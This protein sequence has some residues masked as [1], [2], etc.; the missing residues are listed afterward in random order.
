[1]A[2][3]TREP[4]FEATI[5]TTPLDRACAPEQGK[6]V[7]L[8]TI[9]GSAMAFIDGTVVN[10]ALP[11]LQTELNATVAQ[12]QWV[13][14]AYTLMLAALILAGGALGD[15]FGRRRIYGIGVALFAV[16]RSGADWRPTID[17]L[18]VARAVQGVGGALLVPGS[19]AII[20][21]PRSTRRAAARAIGTWSGLLVDHHRPRAGRSAAVWWDR[22][23]GGRPF[24]STCRWR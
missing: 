24:S 20:S 16:A 13:V 17:Q 4:C 2:L 21:A 3:A 9:L 15:Q 8:A 7:L 23:R 22:C 12:V 19:L 14:E 18:I 5:A 6:W 10:V 11:V 1:M